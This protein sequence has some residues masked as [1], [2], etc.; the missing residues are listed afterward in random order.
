MGLTPQNWVS[1]GNARPVRVRDHLGSLGVLP[2]QPLF[3][4]NKY[5]PVNIA[6]ES[7]KKLRACGAASR[8]LL[9]FKGDLRVSFPCP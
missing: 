4:F 8:G 2:A 7:L 3:F 6:R 5:N 1:P 9:G